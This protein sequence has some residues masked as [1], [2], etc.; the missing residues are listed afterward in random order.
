MPLLSR[1]NFLAAGAASAAPGAFL[2]GRASAEPAD[3]PSREIRFVG[4]GPMLSPAEYADLL[5]KLTQSG[6]A[7]NDLYLKGGAVEELETRFAKELGKEQ[8]IYVPTGTLANHLAV[9]RLAGER[10]RVLVQAE[11]HLYCDAYD[12]AQTLS[13]LNVVPLAGGRATVTFAE[14]EEAC[15]RAKDGPHPVPVGAIAIECPVRRRLGEVVD[16]DEMKRITDF[17]RNERIGTHLDGARLYIATAYSGIPVQK[18]AAL[19]DTVYVSLY[20]YFGAG[21]GAILAGPRA[22]IELI[23]RDRMV[24]GGG[25]FQAWP[26]AAVALHSV[27]GFVE[28]F[29]KTR[30]AAEAFFPELEKNSRFQIERIPRGT[31]IVKLRVQGIKPA[32]YTAA[33]RKRGILV[34]AR[35][36]ST[37]FTLTVNETL[38]RRAPDEIAGD[39]VA[40]LSK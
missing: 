7:T 20:K 2:A 24:F 11:S 3:T 32:A 15:Q 17:A 10:S 37:D 36:G 18:Y 12:C 13:H 4:D 9:R 39:F 40:A 25:L 38:L 31:N 6:K 29:Q 34:G 21:A 19:F 28:R 27:D 5:M 35:P 23:A 30:A 22:L 1:R 33:L 16:F 14:V 26:F 8:A